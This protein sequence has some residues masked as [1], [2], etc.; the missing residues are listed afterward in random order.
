MDLEFPN[1]FLERLESF[2]I[3]FFCVKAEAADGQTK[4]AILVIN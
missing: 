4:E 3:F 1:F 2:P